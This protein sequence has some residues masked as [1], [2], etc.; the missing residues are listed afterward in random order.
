M[1]KSLVVYGPKA[2]GKTTNGA[3]LA[4]KFGLEAV[5]ELEDNRATSQAAPLPPT[6]YLT[7]DERTAKR[8]AAAHEF[9]V[10]TFDAAMQ[11]PCGGVK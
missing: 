8:F 9:D 2:C 5:V 3:M 6:L 11:W 7:Y 10:M 1:A 4:K